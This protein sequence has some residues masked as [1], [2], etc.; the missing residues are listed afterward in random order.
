MGARGH[1]ALL[2]EIGTVEGNNGTL[3]PANTA[4]RAQMAQVLYN[5][6]GN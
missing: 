5:L 1:D 4:T 3:T 2:V 6:L